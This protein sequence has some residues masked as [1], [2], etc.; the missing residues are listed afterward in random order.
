MLIG[1]WCFIL[2]FLFAF[3]LGFV[4]F[5]LQVLGRGY[6]FWVFLLVSAYTSN[7]NN[8][9]HLSGRIRIKKA[10][11]SINAKKNEIPEWE[12]K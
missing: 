2:F 7:P 9:F 1:V 4:I 8:A 12:N 6:L 10:M 11:L 3:T 5:I